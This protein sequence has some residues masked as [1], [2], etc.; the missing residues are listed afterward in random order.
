MRGNKARSRRR[1]HTDLLLPSK[2]FL[3]H[4]AAGPQRQ[5]LRALASVISLHTIVRCIH[6]PKVDQPV[7]ATKLEFR[8]V[9]IPALM[10]AGSLHLLQDEH[11]EVCLGRVRE[12]RP[13]TRVVFEAIRL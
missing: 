13:N 6:V 1:P 11:C 3:L 7:L 2:K 9:E 8:L 5:S 10:D 12:K 4:R